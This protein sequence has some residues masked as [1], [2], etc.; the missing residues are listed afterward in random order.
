LKA[1]KQVSEIPRS[2][3]F[4]SRPTLEKLFE[5]KTIKDKEER[6]RKIAQAVLEYGYSQTEI[7]RILGLHYSTISN[8][9]REKQDQ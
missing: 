4:A 8:L 1:Y 7:V 5:E 2:Q 3:R 9:L 6:N